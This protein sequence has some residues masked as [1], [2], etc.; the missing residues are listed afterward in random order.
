MDLSQVI[1]IAIVW[2]V[3]DLR[4]EYLREKDWMSAGLYMLSAMLLTLL[5]LNLLVPHCTVLVARV[6]SA[7]KGLSL[8]ISFEWSMWKSIMI[9]LLQKFS[10]IL[11]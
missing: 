7:L 4:K 10:G 6:N 9:Y 2:V 8:Q 3:Y 1:L 5:L 11:G